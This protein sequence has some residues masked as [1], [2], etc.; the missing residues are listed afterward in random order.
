MEKLIDYIIQKAEDKLNMEDGKKCV[1][2]ECIFS[3][4]SKLS[5]DEVIDAIKEYDSNLI[6]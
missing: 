5:D 2:A 4:L 1:C 3:S 6:N